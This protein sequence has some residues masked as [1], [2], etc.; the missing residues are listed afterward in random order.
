M[1]TM[2][3]LHFTRVVCSPSAHA[4]VSDDDWPSLLAARGVG[5]LVASSAA[6]LAAAVPTG[7]ATVG[8][9][10][11]RDDTWLRHEVQLYFH[12]GTHSEIAGKVP[13]PTHV[14][15]PLVAQYGAGVRNVLRWL[16]RLDGKPADL[17]DHRDIAGHALACAS[18]YTWTGKV[19]TAVAT[20]RRAAEEI[21]SE[22]GE[23]RAVL[24]TGFP[25]Y[26]TLDVTDPGARVDPVPVSILTF[27]STQADEFSHKLL[28]PSLP[29]D[30][31]VTAEGL[32]GAGVGVNAGPFTAF[33][34][35][36]WGAAPPA[37]PAAGSAADFMAAN[38]VDHPDRPWP[39]E[40]CTA[41]SDRA[42]FPE[43]A[44]ERD[45]MTT[46]VACQ[47]TPFLPRAVGVLGS[48]VDLVA[49]VDD[50]V[51]RAD[52]ANRI[53]D[54][55]DRH[56]V[57]F[58]HDTRWPA[59]LYG[60][61][62]P[63]DVFVVSRSKFFDAVDTMVDAAYGGESVAWMRCTVPATVTWLPVTSLDYELGKYFALCMEPID[64]DEA[65]ANSLYAARAAFAA[66]VDA[67]AVL[68]AY[69]N[70]SFYLQQLADNKTVQSLLF[71]RL[72]RWRTTPTGE[73][74]VGGAKL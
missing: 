61:N 1:T 53:T 57:W 30:A 35:T 56:P 10:T 64:V 34:Y 46:C 58:R 26:C 62:G 31:T 48:D 4:E 72:E 39:C 14:T 73:S 66:V 12:T 19:N 21:R 15:V 17:V 68:D 16:A 6:E 71:D 67:T 70:D 3:Q 63:L 32:R 27:T 47:Q 13:D 24:G 25:F 69:T 7:G 33:E 8:L 37:P 59:Q 52:L 9:G 50:D 44:W 54:W 22:F 41:L 11:G 28:A 2:H 36:R 42:K 65:T 5:Y 74:I 23:I 29:L 18:A 43:Q 45:F 40:L 20:V 55:I 51:D 49:L 38:V 60:R